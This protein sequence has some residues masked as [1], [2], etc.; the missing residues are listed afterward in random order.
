MSASSRRELVRYMINRGLSERRALRVIGMSASSYR[1]RPSPD[2]NDALRQ[3]IVELAHRYRRY[4]AG[5]IYLKLRQA[6]IVVKH[7]RVELL[8]AEAEQQVQ[9]SKRKKVPV[10]DRQPLIRPAQ[11]NQIRSM[12]FVFDRTAD[13]RV[14]KSLTIVD[15]ATHEC[16][17][18]VAERAIG[19][20]VLTRI[21]DRL[22]LSRGNTQSHSDRQWQGILRECHARLGARPE[23]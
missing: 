11:A 5:M 2:R 17:A 20:N 7:K 15:D 13:A 9:R 10:S 6:G 19:G 4:G 1:Y 8:Y 14:I 23:T 3:Q 12:D 18:I 16:V 22:A 21:L